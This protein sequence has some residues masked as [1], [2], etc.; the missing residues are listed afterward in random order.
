MYFLRTESA[1]A[2]HALGVRIGALLAAGD[3]VLL[4]GPLGAG[5]TLLTKGIGEGAGSADLIA[6]PTFVLINEYH[7]RV[8]LYHVDLYRLDDPAEILA[9][10]LPGYTA[11]GVLIVEW[12]ER[13]AGLLPETHLHV[14]LAYDGETARRITITAFGERPAQLLRALSPETAAAAHG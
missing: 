8:K 9:L 6:S 10:D 11:D 1:E 3:V 4:H 7:G 5:K 2:T 14:D 12:P 13:G